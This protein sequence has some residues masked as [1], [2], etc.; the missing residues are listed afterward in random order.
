MGPGLPL[1]HSQEYSA[2]DDSLLQTP[3]D[4]EKLIVVQATS[5]TQKS[6]VLRLGRGENIIPGV[7][8]L[9]S[10]EKISIVGECLEASRE[11]SLWKPWEPLANIP[12]KK[13][14]IITYNNNLDSVWNKIPEL[15]ETLEEKRT[16]LL[17]IPPPYWILRYSVARTM[18]ES[19]T[20]T[21]AEATPERRS[22]QMEVIYNKH[23]YRKLDW[24]FGGRYDQ[25][26]A[27]LK[28]PNLIIPTNRYFLIGE[29]TFNFDKISKTMNN[30]YAAVGTGFGYSN[31]KVDSAVSTGYS[32][33]FPVVR[34]GF[35]TNLHNNW[36]LLTEFVGEAIGSTE[37]F[38]GG[39][40]QKTNIINAK[41]AL[42]LRF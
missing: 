7:R 6:F 24:G 12:F 20:E 8:A 1:A 22:Q 5:T 33:L 10:T 36:S 3:S 25:E 26:T 34:L 41:F 16:A 11:Y 39:D 21:D 9:F 15:K 31:T 19:T 28:S 13:G 27:I 40:V 17:F 35:L 4:I 29:I 32:L 42:G 14:Q 37:K 2:N 38:S 18:Q 30:M 23:L